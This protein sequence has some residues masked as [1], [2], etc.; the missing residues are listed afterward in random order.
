M[1]RS[2]TTLMVLATK[3]YC[4]PTHMGQYLQFSTHHPLAHKR[5]LV[6]T[7]IKWAASHCSTEKRKWGVLCEDKTLS[8]WLPRAVLPWCSPGRKESLEKNDPKAHT[9]I[10]YVQGILET[11]AKRLSHLD[12]EVHMKAKHTLRS[13]L[14]HPKPQISGCRQIDCNIQDRLSWLWCQLCWR[15]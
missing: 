15:D 1:S 4:K 8:K 9:T 12:I 11:V 13:I 2:G 10:P 6:S 5:S 7:L 3:I 14:S